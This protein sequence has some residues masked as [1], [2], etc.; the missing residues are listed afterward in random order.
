MTFHDLDLAEHLSAQTVS[1]GRNDVEP[2]LYMTFGKRLCDLALVVLIL[3][4]LAPVILGLWLAVRR[5]GGAGF[6]G[7][8]RIG[9]NGRA[10]KCWKL[11]SMVVDAEAKLRDHL[12]QNPEAAEEWA[13]DF[14]LR[15]DPRITRLGRFLRK[16]S[17]DE[18]PQLWNVITGEMSFV[19]PRPVPEVE[20]ALYGAARHYYE[21]LRPGVTGLWQVSGRN[22]VTYDERIAMDVAYARNLSLRGDLRIL[23]RTAHA[24][25]AR[26]G[27]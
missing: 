26:T 2:S 10:F 1:R 15:N 25:L 8:T 19:G 9:R 14:K 23:W 11:R 6:F 17:L 18:L 20:L 22:N 21:A 7:H 4:I 16:S 12:A 3:P 24:V 13:R 5:D 27:V